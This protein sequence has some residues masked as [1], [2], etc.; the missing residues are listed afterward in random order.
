LRVGGIM[1][2]PVGQTNAVQ[3]LIKIEK[4]ENGL[5]YEEL[6]PVRFVPLIEGVAREP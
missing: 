2:L 1:V 5:E 4:M 3:H 6:G